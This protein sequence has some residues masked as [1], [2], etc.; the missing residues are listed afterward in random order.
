MFL[1]FSKKSPPQYK[2]LFLSKK[3]LFCVKTESK[4]TFTAHFGTNVQ[5][6]GTKV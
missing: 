1:I 6:F 4:K 2:R 3:R 5:D